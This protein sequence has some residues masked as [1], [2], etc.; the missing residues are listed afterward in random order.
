LFFPFQQRLPDPEGA[1]CVHGS[2]ITQRPVP[3][4]LLGKVAWR[5]IASTTGL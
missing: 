5:E 2:C 1:R 4:T 3:E